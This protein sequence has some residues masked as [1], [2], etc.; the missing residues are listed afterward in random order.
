MISASFLCFLE[1][2]AVAVE[3]K[4]YGN[5]P[6]DALL[7]QKARASKKARKVYRRMKSA[8]T[9]KKRLSEED[10]EGQELEELEVGYTPRISNLRRNRTNALADSSMDS[11]PAQSQR[12][13]VLSLEVAQ[14][15]QAVCLVI[16]YFLYSPVSSLLFQAFNCKSAHL[17]FLRAC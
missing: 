11:A 4:F 14:Q 9:T 8:V 1:I 12:R 13:A 17:E 2:I 10:T 15:I 5:R 7:A 16:A 3:I 6:R